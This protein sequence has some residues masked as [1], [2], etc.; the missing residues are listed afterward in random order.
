M[1]GDFTVY[2]KGIPTDWSESDVLKV[3]VH[4]EEVVRVSMVV[5]KGEQRDYCYIEFKSKEAAEQELKDN[6][7]PY[8]LLISKP[9]SEYDESST[10][11]LCALPETADESKLRRLFGEHQKSIVEIR[12]KLDRE[13]NYAYV[14][15][16]SAEEKEGAF[17][18]VRKQALV[19]DGKKVI[20]QR[21][22]SS[23]AR[24]KKFMPVVFLKKLAY[25]AQA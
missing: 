18:E 3:L 5:K 19:V 6:K 12:L 17:Q 1:D 13:K 8:Q 24:N 9:P 16:S 25:K 11:F 10:L 21:C 23:R 2:L 14:E 7:S 4:P 15:F 20:V 22:D